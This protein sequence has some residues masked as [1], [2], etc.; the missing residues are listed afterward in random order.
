MVLPCVGDSP[1]LP[2]VKWVGGHLARLTD[3][4]HAGEPFGSLTKAHPQTT[5]HQSDCSSSHQDLLRMCGSGC[6]TWPLLFQGLLKYSGSR[7]AARRGA[8]N[9][10]AQTR[11]PRQPPQM[12]T[13]LAR[14]RA[15]VGYYSIAAFSS[16]PITSRTTASIRAASSA[17]SSVV[18]PVSFNSVRPSWYRFNSP[19]SLSPYANLTCAA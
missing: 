16:R 3:R 8:G 6:Q 4:P 17:C 1:A 9:C 10:D 14:C 2:T 15:S 12:P 18:N 7:A 13:V 19:K 5:G 11:T